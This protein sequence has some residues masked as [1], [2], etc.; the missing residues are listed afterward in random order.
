MKIKYVISLGGREE[1]KI[2]GKKFK[3]IKINKKNILESQRKI[4]CGSTT[5][6]L[7]L[8]RKLNYLLYKNN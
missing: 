3:S 6:Y 1:L 8:L 7:H 5:R 2:K 4:L